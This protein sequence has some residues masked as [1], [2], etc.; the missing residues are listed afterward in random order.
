MG[1][2]SG[3]LRWIYNLLGG[4]AILAAGAA[5]SGVWPEEGEWL[6]RLGYAVGS[7]DALRTVIFWFGV[8]CLVA[9]AGLQITRLLF[10]LAR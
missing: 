3:S 9:A 6:W 1:Q 7:L 5:Q 4:G 10:R 2:E 8:L